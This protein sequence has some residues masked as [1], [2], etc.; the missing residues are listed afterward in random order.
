MSERSLRSPGVGRLRRGVWI[1]LAALVSLLVVLVAIGLGSGIR[2][3]YFEHVIAT[4]E[5]R[6]LHSEP[7]AR[8]FLRRFRGLNGV[9]QQTI[10]RS[11]L[12]GDRWIARIQFK[13]PSPEAA[14][15]QIQ[16]WMQSISEPVGVRLVKAAYYQLRVYR[17]EHGDLV[18]GTA[19]PVRAFRR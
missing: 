13:A 2:G 15:H 7:E 12:S 8:A 10:A 4:F 17:P 9:R 11:S 5:L 6:G 18:F 3:I 14:H 1:A 16:A 19:E